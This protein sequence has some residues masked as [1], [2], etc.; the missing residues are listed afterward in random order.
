MNEKIPQEQRDE[1]MLLADGHHIIWVEGLRVNMAY[2]VTEHTKRVLEIQ[3]DK[4]E[5][6][7]REN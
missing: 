2:Q 1:I 3:I 5:S 4:G 6:Y 7:G